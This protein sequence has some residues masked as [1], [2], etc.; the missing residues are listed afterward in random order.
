LIEIITV[1]E[2]H[3]VV[4]SKKPITEYSIHDTNVRHDGAWVGASK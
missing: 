4:I 3:G 2:Q 1:A